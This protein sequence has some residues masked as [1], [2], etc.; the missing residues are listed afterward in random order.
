[1]FSQEVRGICK[2][3][4]CGLYGTS[5]ACPAAV[6]RLE[7]CRKQCLEYGGAFISL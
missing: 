2:G 6:G 3:N 1:M 4:S 5:W 7:E